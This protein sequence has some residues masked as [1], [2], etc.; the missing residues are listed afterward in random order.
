M[1]TRSHFAK[2]DR[3]SEEEIRS[4]FDILES[5]KIFLDV[6]GTSSGIAAIL[7]KNRQIVYGNNELLD[8]LGIK[9][10]DLILGKRP[11]EA[12]SCLHSDETQFGCGT[13]AACSVCGAVNAILTSQQTG[14]KT[15]RDTRITTSA[16]GGI[17]SF[18]LKVT[19]SPLQIH[20]RQY[21]VF[22]LQDISN[23]KRME[24]LEKIF[25]HDLLN[26]AGSLNGLL[27]MLKTETDP[28]EERSLIDMSEE[29]SRDIIDEII[30]HGKLRKAENGD[31]VPDFKPHNVADLV[32]SVVEKIKGDYVS[33]KKEILVSE[34]PEMIC[35]ETD[36][37]LFNRILTNM[38]RNA[39]E[40]TDEG[41]VVRI[42]VIDS[43]KN[44]RFEV[45]NN[46]VMKEEVKHQIFQRSFSTKGTGRGT[47]TYSI[48]L[49]TENYLN[50]IAGFVSTEDIG[51]MF[52]VEFLKG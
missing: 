31:L 9:S 34:I 47:G 45:Q 51:T 6:F 28:N 27:T 16:G 18:D 23:E 32:N 35:F 11:G 52:F 36:R 12:V 20:G 8:L 17:R 2:P 3:S 14:E 19:S 33:R 25:L 22:T 37:M 43:I 48:K 21:Y 46:K 15:V 7:D 26:T 5:E 50:G 44:V 40:A 24:N 41:G 49:L 30:I 29:A 4:D 13:S 42:G 38:V 10:M 39:L 1:E